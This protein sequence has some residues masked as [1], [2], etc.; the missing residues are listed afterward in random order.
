MPRVLRTDWLQRHEV[1]RPAGDAG[2]EVGRDGRS[3][4]SLHD[5]ALEVDAAARAFAGKAVVHVEL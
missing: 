2:D 3:R 1:H 4:K 5:H